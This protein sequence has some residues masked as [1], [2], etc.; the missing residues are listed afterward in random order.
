MRWWAWPFTEER[1]AMP[2]AAD[3]KAALKKAQA[4]PPVGDADHVA[5]QFP[6][7]G[8]PLPAIDPGSWDDA[9]LKVVDLDDVEASNAQLGKTDLLWHIAHPFQAKDPAE[10]G[11]HPQLVKQ[12]GKLVIVG[13]HHRMSALAMLGVKKAPALVLKA[14]KL[15]SD[16]KTV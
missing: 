7:S 1:Q 11:P 2:S 8:K 15:D 10:G 14:K 16:G 3:I 6:V 13:G 12:G 4:L 9:K 5:A